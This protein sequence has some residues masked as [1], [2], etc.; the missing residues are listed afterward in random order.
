MD[1]IPERV[2]I[3]LDGPS[4]AAILGYMQRNSMSLSQALRILIAIGLRDEGQSADATFRA[5][6]FREGIIH[7]V[8][9]IKEQ[10]QVAIAAAMLDAPKIPEPNMPAPTALQ[11]HRP[12]RLG[13]R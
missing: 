11:G 10:L 3:R 5:A 7:G 13:G 12:T 1:A 2:T 8:A 6:A 9:R 4:R